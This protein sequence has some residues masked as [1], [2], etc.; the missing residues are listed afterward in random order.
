[1]PITKTLHEAFQFF[2]AK[3]ANPR[4]GWAAQSDDGKTVVVTMWRDLIDDDGKVLTYGNRQGAGGDS[5]M[6]LPGNRD[7]IRK[8]QHVWDNCGRL[9]RVVII[10]AVDT[11]AGAR[12]TRKKYYAAETLV[13]KLDSP[14]DPDTGVFRARSVER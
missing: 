9:F 10:D 12:N 2:K 8:L 14:V 1:M 4:W 3:A 5:W 13:M 7:R 11:K 6:K